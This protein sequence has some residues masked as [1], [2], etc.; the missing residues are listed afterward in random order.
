MI[1]PGVSGRRESAGERSA[2]VALD[3]GL[4]YTVNT[5]GGDQNDLA[6]RTI[7]LSHPESPARSALEALTE[8]DDS[9]LPAGTK[10]RSVKIEDGLAS[11]DFSQEF[12]TNF[13]GS[14][15]EEAQAINSILRTMGQFPS[16]TRVQIL[17]EGKAIDAL[18]QLDIS[19]PLEV[20]RPD[21]V[22][23]AESDGRG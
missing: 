15:T 13:H 7:A 14:E 23:Q 6:P 17:V 19:G 11:V 2:P 8:A 3:H 22:R 10:L 12:Q 5:K 20:I 1:G 9:P 18:S 4:I 16:V 21:P